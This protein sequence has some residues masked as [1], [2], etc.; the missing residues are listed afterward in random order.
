MKTLNRTEQASYIHS[1]KREILN[2]ASRRWTLMETCGGQTNTI[3]K[4]G[5]DELLQDVVRFIHGP[6]CPVCVTPEKTLEAVQQ[7]ALN[8]D[9]ILVSFGDMLR[10]PAYDKTL[11]ECKALGA[12]IRMVYSPLDSLCIAENHPDK[13]VVFFAIGF[14]TTAPLHALT[15][16]EAQRRGL[17]NYTVYTSLNLV[18][19]A[20]KLICQDKDSEVDGLLAAGHVCA[21]VGANAYSKLAE[22]CQ[23]PISITGFEPIDML[24]GILNNIKQLE[25]NEHSV[26]NSY[27]RI[28]TNEG[29]V[30]AQ[31]M[32]QLVFESVDK[33]WRGIGVISQSG[34]KIK[35]AFKNF[36][37]VER[38]SIIED[39]KKSDTPCRIGEVMRG[40]ISPDTCPWFGVK[41]NPDRPLGAAMVSSE[42]ACA[43]YYKYQKTKKDG[44]SNT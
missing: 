28:V 42:G 25:A 27:Q 21:V 5:I 1:L 37:A 4:F 35:K 3:A 24:W 26:C 6:G 8:Q 16:L 41:C 39:V 18:P 12:D 32:M 13:E 44:M 33:E 34:L 29:N 9:I 23:I 14:E 22:S 15:I 11:L 17:N 38:F 30:K 2:N 20:I 10:V 36:D 19:P 31:K 43:S 40:K 7:L